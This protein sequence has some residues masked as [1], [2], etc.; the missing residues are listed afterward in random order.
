VARLCQATADGACTVEALGEAT[1]AGTG[2][3]SCRDSLAQL[4]ARQP[5]APK[6]AAAG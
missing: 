4:I 2:C 3:G 1:K 6:L 5:P